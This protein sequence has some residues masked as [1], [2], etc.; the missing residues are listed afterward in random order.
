[1]LNNL[2]DLDKLEQQAMRSAPIEFDLPSMVEDL[3]N[4]M[5][6]LAKKGQGLVYW[7]EGGQSLVFLD[8]GMVNNILTNLVSNA[9]KYSPPGSTITLRTQMDQAGVTI[10][11]ED[12]GVGIPKEEQELLFERFFRGSNVVGS[13]GIGLGLPIVKEY[14]ELMGGSITVTSETGRTLFV[15]TL[16]RRMK[17]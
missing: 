16:P 11:V 8:Q 1:M 12:E 15:V 13:K 6:P 10:S 3:L 9:I 2:L 7:H 4:E 17:P 14:L 5:Q